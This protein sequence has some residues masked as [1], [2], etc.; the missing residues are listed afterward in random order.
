MNE[1]EREEEVK[2]HGKKKGE[3]RR[4]EVL[5]TVVRRGVLTSGWWSY[6]FTTYDRAINKGVDNASQEQSI[7]HLELSVL[8]RFNYKFQC[9]YC[10]KGPI[11][12]C[13]EI[14][15]FFY[16]SVIRCLSCPSPCVTVL[17]RV[18]SISLGYRVHSFDTRWS[19]SRI[20]ADT[21]GNIPEPHAS[22]AR[23]TRC[24]TENSTLSLDRC[25]GRPGTSEV[26]MRRMMLERTTCVSIRAP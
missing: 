25:L 18:L 4:T 1:D 19:T 13:P 3:S 11:C 15:L 17:S 26:A 22:S 23:R 7:M 21:S 24:S 6:C 16:P 12:V 8:I 9:R 14:D 5:T 2:C 20:A 10:T